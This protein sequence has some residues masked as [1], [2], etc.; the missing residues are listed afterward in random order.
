MSLSILIEPAS[1]CKS[2]EYFIFRKESFFFSLS[3]VYLIKKNLFVVSFFCFQIWIFSYTFILRRRLI[4]ST[5]WP[6]SPLT[7]SPNEQKQI[8]YGDIWYHISDWKSLET[9][10]IIFLHNYPGTFMSF[11]VQ[12]L[13]WLIFKRVRLREDRWGV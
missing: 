7:V 13:R 3:A 9:P 12:I 4:L 10:R 5:K 1:S 8:S 11:E 2:I 6:S